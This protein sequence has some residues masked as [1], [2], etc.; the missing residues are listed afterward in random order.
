MSRVLKLKVYENRQPASDHKGGLIVIIELDR[1]REIVQ[2]SLAVTATL[3]LHF[4]LQQDEVFY[5]P[6]L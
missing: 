2:S 3:H 4:P 6:T 1:F 5:A